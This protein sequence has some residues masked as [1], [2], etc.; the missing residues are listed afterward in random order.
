[1]T[2]PDEIIFDPKGKKLKNLGF[3]DFGGNFPDPEADDQT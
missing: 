2:Q 3:W 1:L